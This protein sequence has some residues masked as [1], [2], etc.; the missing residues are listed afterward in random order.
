V[1][2]FLVA[3]KNCAQSLVLTP[4]DGKGRTEW[5]AATGVN[6]WRFSLTME[7]VVLGK[8]HWRTR[9]LRVMKGFIVWAAALALT[10]CATRPDGGSRFLDILF[11]G[12]G[13]AT[14]GPAYAAPPPQGNPPTYTCFTQPAPYG[15]GGTTTCLPQPSTALPPSGN[16]P[17][18]TCFTQPYGGGAT[19]T[20]L[21]H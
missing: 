18:V 5:C 15:G 8:T 10:A 9:K 7:N 4:A 13:A 17:S 20:C 6:C 11:G 12:A 3:L 21:P 2:P 16:A 1:P 14:P 19:T